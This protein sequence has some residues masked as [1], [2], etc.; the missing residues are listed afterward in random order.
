MPGIIQ[1]PLADRV[2]AGCAENLHSAA[3][4][5]AK[6]VEWL[7]DWY[8]AGAGDEKADEEEDEELHGEGRSDSVRLVNV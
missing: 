6:E 1:L 8:G 4:V 7:G 3:P 5:V 2:R